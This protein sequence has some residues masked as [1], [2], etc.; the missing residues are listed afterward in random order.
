MNLRSKGRR[1][2]GRC[3]V[4]P[5]PSDMIDRG[6]W[7]RR[8]AALLFCLGRMESRNYIRGIDAWEELDLGS[9]KYA[10]PSLYGKSGRGE[11]VRIYT[12]CVQGFDTVACL[13]NLGSNA[14]F[15][16]IAFWDAVS[17]VLRA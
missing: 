17:V 5:S 11:S 14:S 16:V 8:R 6:C 9:D 12:N 15:N 4:G 3:I 2:I 13:N 1:G 7:L 10:P